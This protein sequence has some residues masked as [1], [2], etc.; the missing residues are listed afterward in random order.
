[1]K[2]KNEVKATGYYSYE[3]HADGLV[4]F[5]TKKAAIH[6]AEKSRW[7]QHEV[8]SVYSPSGVL[9]WKE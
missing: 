5:T 1:M 6:R 9:V 8:K 4:E 3:N 7:E 2:Q